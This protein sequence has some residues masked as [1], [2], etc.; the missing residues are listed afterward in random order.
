[1]EHEAV[2][3]LVLHGAF[4]HLTSYTVAS[5]HSINR[6]QG[7]VNLLIDSCLI[8]WLF[9]YSFTFVGCV[10]KWTRWIFC[11]CASCADIVSNTK[12]RQLHWS[13]CGQ[14]KVL[15]KYVLWC[16]AVYPFTLCAAIFYAL[17]RLME[18]IATDLLR[19]F[20]LQKKVLSFLAS[21][22]TTCYSFL[23]HCIFPH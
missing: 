21:P 3:K 6:R 1:M 13:C 9:F 8:L 12:I 14:L 22:M 20:S 15:D 16:S 17:S 19:P 4:V 10:L 5:L 18:S 2:L 7:K 23:N 11:V